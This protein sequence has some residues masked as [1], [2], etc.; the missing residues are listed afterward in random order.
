MP[1]NNGMISHSIARNIAD[2]QTSLSRA[3]NIFYGGSLFF[4]VVFIALTVQ[5]HKYIVNASTAG[6]PLSEAVIHGKRVWERNAASTVTRC[7]AKV[8]ISRP[9]LATS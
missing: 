2:A 3:R 4:V 6:T 1:T 8:P 7:T 5:S 9:S